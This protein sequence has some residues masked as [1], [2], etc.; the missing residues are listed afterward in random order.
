MEKPADTVYPINELLA[1]RWSPRAFSD[2]PVELEKL[3]SLFEGARW[4]A[5]SFNEQPWS[6]IVAT[7]QDPDDFERLADCLVPGN[8]A[9][10]KEAPV[11][12]LSV[13][14]MHFDRNNKPNRHAY[15]DVGLAMQNLIVQATDSGLSVHQMAGFDID[16]A[17][18]TFEIPEGFEPVA[19]A[20]IGY[21]VDLEDLPDELRQGELDPRSRNGFAGFVFKGKWGEPLPF[22]SRVKRALAGD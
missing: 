14:K 20:A 19:M 5:S 2:Q 9:W 3:Y 15:H 16:K 4:S 13:A 7:K 8:K 18:E 12:I 17:R 11:L 22:D 1:G 6:F 21:G 10:A